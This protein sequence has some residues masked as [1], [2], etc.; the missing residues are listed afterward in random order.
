MC[1]A[2]GLVRHCETTAVEFVPVIPIFTPICLFHESI[3]T[4]QFECYS[5]TVHHDTNMENN[6]IL[7]AAQVNLCLYISE[8]VSYHE[9]ESLWKSCVFNG[10]FSMV[11]MTTTLY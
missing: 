7:G 4:S 5:V 10:T 2:A 9:Q 3:V 6:C 8:N 11:I 1:M